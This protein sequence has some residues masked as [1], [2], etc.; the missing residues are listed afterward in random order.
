MSV[1]ETFFHFQCMQSESFL[2]SFKFQNI[3]TLSIWYFTHYC[4]MSCVFY[5]TENRTCWR[6]SGIHVR[7]LFHQVQVSFANLYTLPSL[8]GFEIQLYLLMHMKFCCVK[9]RQPPKPDHQC[10]E[11][12]KEICYDIM[13]ETGDN[14]PDDAVRGRELYSSL[15]EAITSQ[16]WVMIYFQSNVKNLNIQS[17]FSNGLD[18]FVSS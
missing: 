11:T 6:P 3:R 17:V 13:E 7:T 10:D 18:Q 12:M 14:M 16:L 8:Y 9:K 4:D 1:T 2:Y 5:T 15:R